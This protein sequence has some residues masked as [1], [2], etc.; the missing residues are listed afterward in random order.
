M[1]PGPGQMPANFFVQPVPG[2]I[3]FPPRGPGYIIVVQAP[4]APQAIIDDVIANVV[5]NGG[6]SSSMPPVGASA[7]ATTAAATTISAA[8]ATSTTNICSAT[9]TNICGA[10]AT[11][12]NTSGPK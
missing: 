7:S 10:S 3:P 2:H 11:T 4:Q 6:N 9:G 5:E 1:P 8:A 12:A